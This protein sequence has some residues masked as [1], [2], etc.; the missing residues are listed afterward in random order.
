MWV[1]MYASMYIYISMCSKYI[2]ICISILVCTSKI[3]TIICIY[4][5]VWSIT[6]LTMYI[7]YIITILTILLYIL[8]YILYII[9]ILSPFFS[10]AD[11]GVLLSL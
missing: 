9:Y 1:C 2:V 6:I 4:I 7:Y 8:I 5:Y 3:L 10:L 11:P